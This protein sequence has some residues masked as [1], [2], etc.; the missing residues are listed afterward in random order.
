MCRLKAW[1]VASL[2]LLISVTGWGQS[3]PAM[4][5]IEY[6]NLDA[7]EVHRLEALKT[8]G[9]EEVAPVVLPEGKW[10]SETPMSHFGWPHA[11]MVDGVMVVSFRTHGPR[12]G[13][14]RSLDGGQTWEDPVFIE[15]APIVVMCA[16]RSGKIV[17][18]STDGKKKG[19]LN[20]LISTDKG[21]TWKRHSVKVN[22]PRHLAARIVEHPKYGL[23]TGGHFS[24]DTLTFLV[25]AD[26]GQ[27]WRRVDFPTEIALEN[28]G[29]VVFLYGADQHLGVFARNHAGP[30]VWEPFAQF[31]TVN[32]ESAAR[33]EDLKWKGAT[34][35]IWIRK[36]DTSDAIYNPVT[37]RIEAVTTKRDWG[38][39]HTDRGYMT[40]NLWSIAPAAFREG[41]G[42]WRYE[43]TLLRSK[44]EKARVKDPR[45]GMH[46]VGTVVDEARG[47]QHILI[48]GGDR[49]HGGD[50]AP[51][52]GRT[53]V[54]R[55]SRTLDTKAWVSKN[56]ELDNYDKIYRLD[57]DFVSLDRWSTSGSPTG[58]MT[59]PRTEPPYRTDIKLPK[60]TLKVEKTG[61][62]YLKTGEPGYYGIHQEDVIVTNSVRVSFAAKV[63]RFPRDG[64]PL[65][66]HLSFGGEKYDLVLKE[67][68]IYEL[69]DGDPGRYRKIIDVSVD[70]E[71]HSWDFEL[72]SGRSRIFR[73][74]VFIGNGRS[75]IDGSIGQRPLTISAVAKSKNDP[76]EIRLDRIK[77]ENIEDPDEGKIVN[78]IGME[79]VRVPAGKFR[80]GNDGEIDYS[81]VATD[82]VH[83]RYVGKG[84][85]NQHIKGGP[86]MSAN[87]LEW[88][89]TPSHEVVISTP[90]YMASTPVTNAQY[91]LFRPEHRALRGKRGFSTGDN[92]AVVFVS[93]EDA[94]AFTKWLSEK[95]GRPYRLPTEAEWEY[96]ARAGT[97]TPY[98][99]GDSLPRIYHHHQVMNRTYSLAPEKV[100]LEVGKTPP[101]AWGLHD[102]HGLVEEWCM[103]WY[104]PYT[105]DSK[106]DPVGPEDGFARVTR[107][108]SH[109]TGLPFLRSANRAAALPE[110]AHF[111]IGFRV[112]MGDMPRTK[113]SSKE[114]RPVWAT[115]VSQANHDWSKTRVPRDKPI[116]NEP[117]TYTRIPPDANGP[118]YFIH[119]HNSALT[120]LPN[121]DLLAIWFTTVKE[122]GREMLVAGARLRKG[123]SEWDPA[124][125]FFNVPDRNQTGQA[126]WWDGK[127]KIYHLSGVGT[128]DHWRDLSLVMRTSTDNGVTWS[129]PKII[130]P[131]YGS[132]QQPIAA[133]G[134]SRGE[135]ILACDA[136]P[137]NG[138]SVIHISRDGGETWTDPGKGRPRPT[139]GEG[140]E[141]AWIAGIHAVIAELKDGS[142]LAFGRS[143]D[144]NGRM[145]MSISSDGG[146]TWRYSA[147]DFEPIGSSQR[148][149]MVRLREGPL[150]LVSFS[151]SLEQKDAAGK[152]FT[153]N[154]MF[155][156]VSYDEGKT[157]PVRKLITPGGPRRVL[158]A[159]ASVRWGEEFGTLDYNRSEGRG[160]LSAVQAPD[161]MIHVISSGTHY[162]FNLAWIEA[163]HA[164]IPQ[165]K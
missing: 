155:A 138:G 41:N 81:Q 29:A 105:A 92:D 26:E 129:K 135:I 12:S 136:G 108:G 164:P 38:F 70:L 60:G 98:F 90:F 36:S 11:V 158:D 80:L 6:L 109:S 28:H 106:T 8:D 7:K 71:W 18:A 152:S 42:N 95:E 52:T 19:T 123:N 72:T 30:G 137:D 49:S 40:L 96:A 140:K 93:W 46:P 117:R 3:Y 161:G 82:A 131:E 67:D 147:S 120:A 76:A 94:V 20:V 125:V 86:P 121:G 68:G 73:D 83:A 10:Q 69:V 163:P 22:A 56:R 77:L 63:Q 32:E 132:R 130:A 65:G 139:F 14:I 87:P 119:N 145:P 61:Q 111:L 62:L 78:S 141:G 4:S 35:N 160:Y 64:Y 127:D 149:A 91:E 133:Y 122:R 27:N 44:G 165:D 21:A 115:G 114:E 148:A 57:E 45:D 153:G 151:S 124:D 134:T 84:G 144:I 157:W 43:G 159:P 126:L 5:A 162:S 103:D 17:A 113:P 54:F 112:V 24:L 16:T 150:V 58:T 34:T 156:A 100:D 9:L 47:V 15:N 75:R 118:L 55:V 53:G 101:N 107:G 85:A 79:L 31:V 102:V 146:K 97:T 2:A 51:P 99:T 23:I 142:L 154:G 110:T 50:G 104:G 33:F 74:G 66:V 39:P 13:L 25:S 88:D 1:Y 59:L 128:A 48:Y 143:D 37:D 89:E 116:F